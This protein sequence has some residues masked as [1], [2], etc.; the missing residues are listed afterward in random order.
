M[1]CSPREMAAVDPIDFLHESN[2][3]GH[4]EIALNTGRIVASFL[5]NGK[6]FW[7]SLHIP[8][9]LPR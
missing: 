2:T 9:I 5:Q 1:C 6:G 3:W 8:F 7:L 4:I